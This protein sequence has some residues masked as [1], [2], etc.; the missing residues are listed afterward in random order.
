MHPKTFPHHRREE[1]PPRH[2]LKMT[3]PA[4]FPAVFAEKTLPA[5]EVKEEY[6]N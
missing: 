6:K 3:D 4:Q 5:D 1:P 2:S